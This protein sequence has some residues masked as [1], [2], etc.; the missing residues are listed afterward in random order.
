VP[1]L[2]LVVLA[3]NLGPAR[4]FLDEFTDRIEV[5]DGDGPAADVDALLGRAEVLLLGYPVPP[6][7]AARAPRLRWVHHTQAGVSN[8]HPCDLWGSSVPLTSSRGAVGVTPIAEYAIAGILHFARGIDTA[9]AQKYDDRFTRHGYRMAVVR[10]ATV[11]IIGLGGI[12]RE[13]ARLAVGL[14]M[15]VVGSRR[16]VTEAQHE[17][18][19]VELVLPASEIHALVAQS[20]FVVVCSQLTAETHGMIDAGVFAAM[21]PGAVLVNVARGEE[22]D[23]EALLGA[24]ESGQLKG[25]LLDVYDG[26]LAGRPPRPELVAH[27]RVV[28]TPHISPFGEA[29]LSGPAKDLFVEN[30]R[31]F[32]AGE[33][34]LNLVDRARGY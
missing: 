24:L 33:S 12:G 13:V 34:L 19:G 7:I 15:R 10:G 20:D 1:P 31:R 32:L 11:G 5:L 28:L 2:T 22:I 30:L 27:P 21:K 6:V 8:L 25:A 9:L 16:S 4:A 18:G 29:D 26:E 3:P 17:V 23:E 14:G